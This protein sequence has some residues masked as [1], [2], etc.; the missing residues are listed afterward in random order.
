MTK[1]ILACTIII[2][3]ILSACGNKQKSARVQTGQTEAKGKTEQIIVASTQINCSAIT[4][5]KCLLVKM[6]G[7]TEWRFM[8]KGIEGFEYEPGY[9]YII[10]AQ[11]HYRE[12]P[13]AD[14]STIYYSL[15]RI[16]S[17]EKKGIGGNRPIPVGNTIVILFTI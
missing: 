10:E 8:D 5:M 6:E 2:A 13:A 9:E 15:M 16:L 14:Q 1:I 12:N 17:K 7:D 11:R 4:P 3:V